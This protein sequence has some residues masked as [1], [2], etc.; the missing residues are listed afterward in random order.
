MKKTLIALALTALPVAAMADVTLYGQ[1]KGGLEYTKTNQSGNSLTNINDW[2]SRIGFK[3]E[4]DL[5]N[6]LKAIWQVEQSVSLDSRSGRNSQWASRDSFI[7]VKTPFGTVRAGNLS[8]QTNDMYGVDQW[9]GGNVAALD[10]TFARN[11]VR[12]TAVRYDTP[13]IAGFS[14]NVFYA[15]EDNT[16]YRQVPHGTNGQTAYPVVDANGNPTGNTTALIPNNFTGGLNED[17][18]GLTGAA[19]GVPHFTTV[20]LGLNYEN[21]GFF[22]QYGYVRISNNGASTTQLHLLEGGYDANNIYVG[23]AFQVEKNGIITN[24]TYKDIAL[25]GAYTFGNVTPKLTYA[26]GFATGNTGKYDHVIAGVDYGFSKRTTA[27]FSVGYYK[28]YNFKAH[29]AGLGL[30]HKF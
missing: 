10:N 17:L 8:D 23:L 4:E 25:S 11:G 13:E 29:S 3:G 27:L 19:T 28:S 1:I 7:G 12:T 6:G 30:K 22:A 21:S 16:R 5:G 2:G 9:E 15:P 18:T 24:R 26:H 20:G 14:A